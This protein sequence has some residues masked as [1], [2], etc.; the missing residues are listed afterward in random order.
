MIE[1]RAAH[2]V[3]VAVTW[4]WHDRARLESG[5]PDHVVERVADLAQLLHGDEDAF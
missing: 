4:G 5:K 2:A 1:G 3:T